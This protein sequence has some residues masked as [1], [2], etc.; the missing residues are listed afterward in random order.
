MAANLCS[1]QKSLHVTIMCK[2][3][4]FNLMS[5]L[6][7]LAAGYNE[8][9]IKIDFFGIPG[10]SSSSH[11]ETFTLQCKISGNSTKVS[12]KP[13]QTSRNLVE[14]KAITIQPDD[15]G[16][17]KMS[18]VDGADKDERNPIF[19]SFRVYAQGPPQCPLDVNVTKHTNSSI[20]VTWLPVV[21][22]SLI[23]KKRELKFATSEEAC[24]ASSAA[25]RQ[26]DGGGG[27]RDSETLII[28]TVYGLDLHLMRASSLC[29]MTILKLMANYTQTNTSLSGRQSFLHVSGAELYHGLVYCAFFAISF[30]EDNFK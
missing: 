1:S 17:W 27:P 18:V 7:I 23:F 25:E 15:L 26:E 21:V 29:Q 14:V 11:N 22:I 6:L 30:R 2:L 19:L 3:K 9:E 4:G 13:D 24:H 28:N 5:V 10:D 20:T 16:L 12:K 8:C